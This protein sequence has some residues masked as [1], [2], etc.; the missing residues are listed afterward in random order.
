MLAASGLLL[1]PIH[2]VGDA[3][4]L[5]EFRPLNADEIRMALANQT[6]V[7]DESTDQLALDFSE[8]FHADG[9]W[10]SSRAE[11]SLVQLS[12]RWTITNDQVCVAIDKAPLGRSQSDCR[13]VWRNIRTGQLMMPDRD[14]MSDG[15]IVLLGRQAD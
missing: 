1:A 2:N 4:V 14:R 12:G 15:P 10:T 6:I 8:T 3:H 11:R 9:R 13:K 5:R 7:P